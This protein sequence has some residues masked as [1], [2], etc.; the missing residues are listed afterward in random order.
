MDI[1]FIRSKKELKQ[2][3]SVYNLD[4]IR[5]IELLKLDKE[6]ATPYLQLQDVM[7][8]RGTF[9]GKEAKQLGELE[10]GQIS[11]FK[12][13]FAK[14]TYDTILE[15]FDLIFSASKHQVLRSRVTDYFYAVNW[16]TE[17]MLKLIKREEVAL[18]G[19]PDPTLE[20]AGVSRLQKFQELPVLMDLAQRFGKEI[21]E[22][23]KW[24]YNKVFAMM[25]YFKEQREVDEEYHRLKL[26]MK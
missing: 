10:Y 21:E 23:E 24:K 4:N 20:A 7:N 16:I 12:K 6:S 14:P 18:I 1:V 13:D 8:G 25:Y 11:Q 19:N 2:Q 22:I 26:K 17:Q 9:N 5:V 3:V 15:A